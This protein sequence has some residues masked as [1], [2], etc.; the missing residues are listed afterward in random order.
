MEWKVSRMVAKLQLFT[1]S[2]TALIAWLATGKYKMV[3]LGISNSGGMRGADIML[4]NK[5]ESVTAGSIWQV[6]AGVLGARVAGPGFSCTQP[7][8]FPGRHGRLC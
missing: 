6:G 4:L 2:N 5:Q 3:G 1:C 7:G 8:S